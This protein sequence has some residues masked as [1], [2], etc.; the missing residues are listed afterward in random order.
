VVPCPA[1]CV[2]HRIRDLIKATEADKDRPVTPFNRILLKFP[3]MRAVLTKIKRVFDEA[4]AVSLLRLPSLAFR[5]FLCRT[6]TGLSTT[7]S[8]LPSWANWVPPCLPKRL[9]LCST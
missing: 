7:Q 5:T 4:D 8:S 2:E 6:A 3:A 1:N 9:L